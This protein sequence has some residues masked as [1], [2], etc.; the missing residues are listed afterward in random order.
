MTS[1]TTSYLQG[2]VVGGWSFVI[3]WHILLLLSKQ[4]YGL[5]WTFERVVYMCLPLSKL[6]PLE[7]SMTK[8]TVVCQKVGK[9][10]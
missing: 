3:V 7:T 1:H 6:P 5:S 2:Y 4:G 8:L 9:N 10:L